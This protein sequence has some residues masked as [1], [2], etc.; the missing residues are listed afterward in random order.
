MAGAF[1]G[2][3]GSEKKKKLVNFN[4][5]PLFALFVNLLHSFIRFS[6]PSCSQEYDAKIFQILRKHKRNV[7]T[8]TIFEQRLFIYETLKGS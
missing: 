2:E 6:I 1:E 3:T 7:K 8:I 5:N 4:E